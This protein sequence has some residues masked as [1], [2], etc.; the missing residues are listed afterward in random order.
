MVCQ[1]NDNGDRV[2]YDKDFA[3]SIIR[4]GMEDYNRR[5]DIS[6]VWIKV[7]PSEEFI[8]EKLRNYDHSYLFKA[9]G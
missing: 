1:L 3:N 8:I 7:A 4:A 9:V 2:S 6:I 5:R